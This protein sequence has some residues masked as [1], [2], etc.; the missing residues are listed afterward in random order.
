MKYEDAVA[1]IFYRPEDVFEYIQEM[2]YLRDECISQAEKDST[3]PLPGS[4][5]IQNTELTTWNR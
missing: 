5:I 4:D 2:E 1:G 3:T